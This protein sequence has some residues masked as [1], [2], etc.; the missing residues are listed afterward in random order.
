MKT[1]LKTT[2]LAEGLRAIDGTPFRMIRH[3]S[4]GGDVGYRFTR[5]TWEIYPAGDYSKTI[6]TGASIKSTLDRFARQGAAMTTMAEALA[7]AT[8]GK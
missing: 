5:I 7:R 3:T 8:E 1:T 2:K 4:R 6:A